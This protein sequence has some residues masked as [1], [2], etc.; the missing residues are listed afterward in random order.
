MAFSELKS[1]FV[2]LSVASD[3]SKA[4]LI[5]LFGELLKVGEI[6]RTQIQE[7][8][9]NLQPPEHLAMLKKLEAARLLVIGLGGIILNVE[10]LPRGQIFCRQKQWL[11]F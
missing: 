8:E 3:Q 9:E 2:E 7:L 5:P 1:K 11:G 6:L 10:H 4:Q